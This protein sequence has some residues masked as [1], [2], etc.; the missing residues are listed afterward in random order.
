M[1]VWRILK[2]AGLNKTKPTRKPGL[3]EEMRKARLAWCLEKQHW[4]LDDWKRVIWSDETSV[5]LCK[6]RGGYR[7]WR[8]ADERVV[9]S[10]IRERWKGYSEFLFWGC[11]SYD[12]KGPCHVWWPET[13]AQ[14]K[15]AK[16]EIDALNLTI[17]PVLQARWEEEEACRY[18]AAR[19][20]DPK[21]AR[22]R[23][24][25]FREAT[26]KLVRR[27]GR[28]VDWYRYQKEIIVDKLIPFAK[29]L[30]PNAIVQEDKA[31]A[32]AH[33]AQDE[34]FTI[35][36]VQRLLWC[37]NSPDLNMIEPCWAWMKRQ[38]TRKGAP[39]NRRDGEKVWLDAWDFLEMEQI[40]RW[41]ERIPWH[42]Q[43]I[44]ACQGGNEYLEGRKPPGELLREE[45]MRL[46]MVWE[47]F[48]DEV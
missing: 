11:F 3:S 42:I 14:K 22:H 44:I 12:E 9:K 7:I 15:Q 5:V 24:W 34:I 43:Q 33:H 6:W 16:L 10:C 13:A 2:E 8:A 48:G 47:V 39:Q 20:A 18:A 30:G 32:H 46:A 26:G 40:R 35:A 41:I 36:G 29:K 38:T 25:K 21:R 4:T 45:F 37:G 17:E 19:E 23:K 31:P 28:G 1:S 27:E